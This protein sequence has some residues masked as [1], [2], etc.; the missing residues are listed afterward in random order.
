MA[1]TTGD[2]AYTTHVA[3]AQPTTEFIEAVAKLVQKQRVRAKQYLQ[4]RVQAHEVHL[5]ACHE[6]EWDERHAGQGTSH[7]S[8][9]ESIE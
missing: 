7:R 1:L 9:A 5:R 8:V 6:K 3:D 4:V 2:P